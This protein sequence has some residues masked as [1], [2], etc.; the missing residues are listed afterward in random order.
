[1]RESIRLERE[2]TQEERFEWGE[3]PVCHAPH[4]SPCYADVGAQLGVRVDGRRMRDGEGVHMG[5]LERA[6][7][8][9]RLV[10]SGCP[11]MR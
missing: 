11:R 3:C 8:K 1:M 4:G 9:V 7:M 5:R 2:L 10:P 6:P